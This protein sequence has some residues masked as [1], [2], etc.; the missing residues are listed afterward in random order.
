MTARIRFAA[1]VSIIFLNAIGN[2]QPSPPPRESKGDS[3][4]HF[5]ADRPLDLEHIRL[6]TRVDLKKKTLD[7]KAAIDLTA[8]R[9][10]TSVRFDAVDFKVKSVQVQ[11][12]KS[13]K[14]TDVKY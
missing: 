14:W 8:L 13:E 3:E 12:P 6:D 11:D 7:S 4:M 1:I 10:V 2:G 5:P 9:E